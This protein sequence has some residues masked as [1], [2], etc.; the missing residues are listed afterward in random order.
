MSF[1]ILFL[2][3]AL[4][5]TLDVAKVPLAFVFGLFVLA[6][7]LGVRIACVTSR[8]VADEELVLSHVVLELLVLH[9]LSIAAVFVASVLW[10]STL[11]WQRRVVTTCSRSCALRVTF[12]SGRG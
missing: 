10:R 11:D 9:K 3:H 7:R 6:Q 5:A 8:R 1:Q 2:G 4:A 12:S